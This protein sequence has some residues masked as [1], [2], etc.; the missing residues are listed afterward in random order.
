MDVQ[1][2]PFGTPSVMCAM[3]V[4]L[5][6]LIAL[7]DTQL[8]AW[9]VLLSWL[10]CSLAGVLLSCWHSKPASQLCLSAGEFGECVLDE[11]AGSVALQLDVTPTC[12]IALACRMCCRRAGGADWLLPWAPHVCAPAACQYIVLLP[13]QVCPQFTLT[14]TCVQHSP[15]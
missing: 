2:D 15:S 12:G 14:S 7:V 8:A 5:Q 10:E 6:L 4:G 9:H 11:Q 1:C 13:T 3:Q